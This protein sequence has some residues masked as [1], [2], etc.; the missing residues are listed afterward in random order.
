[1]AKSTD[2]YLQRLEDN[3]EA[4]R[5]AAV[6]NIAEI[7][8]RREQIIEYIARC[9]ISELVR[10]V[11][12]LGPGPRLRAIT[13]DGPVQ[14]TGRR[15]SSPLKTDEIRAFEARVGDVFGIRASATTEWPADRTCCD[16]ADLRR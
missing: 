5:T 2:P 6:P 1:M 14:Y 13:N 12:P 11:L 9:T 15:M 10:Q 8:A 3:F 4:A 16:T 7:R